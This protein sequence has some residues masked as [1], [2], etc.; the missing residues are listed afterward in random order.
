MK[1]IKTI[2]LGILLCTYANAQWV[3]QQVP[4]THRLH[5][6]YFADTSNGWV[7]GQDGIFHTSDG[8]Y[9]WNMQYQGNTS[10]IAGISTTELWAT[11]LRDTLLHTT[12]SGISWDIIN[13][14]SFTDFDSTWSLSCVYFYNTNIGWT[15]AEGWISGGIS[16]PR[17][18]KTTDG[19]ITWEMHTDPWLSSDAYIQFFDSLYGYRTGSELP[20]FRT[21]DGGETWELV[22]WYGYMVTMSM[23]FLTKEIGWMSIDGPVLTTA[24]IKTI[25]GGE[26]WFGNIAFQCSALSTYLSFVDTLT[27]WV[28][29]WSCISPGTE[30]WHTSDGGTSWDLQYIYPLSPRKIFFTDSLHGWVISRYTGTI[31]HTSNGGVIPVELTSFSAEVIDDGVMLNWTTATEINNQGFEIQ[32][33]VGSQQLAV[34][35]LPNGES[36]WETIGYVAGF[37]TTTEPKSYS[38]TDENV[39]TGIYK[40]HL[41]QIDYDGTFSFSDIVEVEF[42][43]VPEEFRLYQNYPNPFNPKTS[44]QYAISSRQ[45][46][47]LKVYDILGNEIATLVNEEK[48]PG[49]YEVEFDASSLASGIYLYQLKTGA[50]VQTNKMVLLR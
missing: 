37:G 21:T 47:T 9:T 19:G 41:K 27:G 2:F 11:S 35:N 4:T 22:S 8:G 39:T 20:F 10:Y 14:N 49:V 32:R 23:Q 15:Q 43:Q 16:S 24:V 44:I 5:D 1:K 6:I 36:S 45:F 30:I 18:L 31:L 29:Q 48:Q 25:N 7:T 42:N 17:L 26:D 13:I 34:G 12:N 46:V 50:F 3:I 38:F 40:Y 33:Q 28:V